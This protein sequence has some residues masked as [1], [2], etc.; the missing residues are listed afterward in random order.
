[1]WWSSLHILHLRLLIHFG[2]CGWN[3][4]PQCIQL[5][6]SELWTWHQRKPTDIN[7]PT[8][9]WFYMLY[10]HYRLYVFVFSPLWDD[11]WSLLMLVGSMVSC[12]L[13]SRSLLDLVQ[14]N[15]HVE[16]TC[17]SCSFFFA[18]S[19]TSDIPLIFGFTRRHR[20]LETIL[21]NSGISGRAKAR[22]EVVVLDPFWKALERTLGFVG[23]RGQTWNRLTFLILPE[24]QRIIRNLPCF[25]DFI[26]MGRVVTFKLD[27]FRRCS[28]MLGLQTSAN[29][30]EEQLAHPHPPG[31]AGPYSH[32]DGENTKQLAFRLAWTNWKYQK[33]H[34]NFPWGIHCYAKSSTTWGNKLDPPAIALLSVKRMMFVK[35]I[36]KCQ[37]RPWISQE[38]SGKYLSI[39]III[40]IYIDM[41][42][43][44]YKLSNLNITQAFIM[45]EINTVPTTSSCWWSQTCFMISNICAVLPKM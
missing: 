31:V 6:N 41:C 33:E 21:P 1:M 23:P 26:G 15:E 10:R 20:F 36:H 22:V 38:I 37:E 42:V 30:N 43:I 29:Y 27:R 3:M 4:I 16:E 24:N 25:F 11:W 7:W 2:I 14:C 5:K 34:H 40:H 18:N 12:D 17:L 39:Y 8:G 13:A 9:W 28:L 44:I 35:C 32:C 19:F 45:R